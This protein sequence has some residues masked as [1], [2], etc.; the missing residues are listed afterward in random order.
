MSATPPNN[1]FQT[2]PKPSGSPWLKVI[3][4]LLGVGVVG[5]I[6][7]C[8]GG[9]YVMNMGLGLAGD[10]VKER[11][12]ADPVIV[13]HLGGLDSAKLNIIATSEATQKSGEDT[14]VFDVSGPS[15][16]G[17]LIF[18]GNDLGMSGGGILEL[19]DGTQHPLAG[20]QLDELDFDMDDIT[21]GEPDTEFEVQ[22][23]EP[24]EVP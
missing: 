18:K 1:P 3:L 21:V 7:C 19:S 15:G 10:Q 5:A 16:Q 2:Q 8:G 20:D 14:Q 17:R 11:F 6:V 13:E 22:L 23:N 4:I 9:I 24:A 12:Q